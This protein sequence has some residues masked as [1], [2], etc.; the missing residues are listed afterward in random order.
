MTDKSNAEH[1]GTR[2]KKL[3]KEKGYTQIELAERLGI[4][5]GYLSEIERGNETP[6]R[7]LYFV[8]AEKLDTNMEYLYSGSS[9]FIPQDMRIRKLMYW[10]ENQEK[11]VQDYVLSM[12]ELTKTHLENIS[13]KETKK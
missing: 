4:T 3:R 7:E 12:I 10:L 5:Q 11:T 6:G 9:E 1:L 8:L 13:E 2:V